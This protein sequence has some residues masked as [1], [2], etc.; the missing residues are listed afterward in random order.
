M[1]F[2]ID[3]I[4]LYSAGKFILNFK[5][6]SCYDENYTLKNIPI[7]LPFNFHTSMNKNILC[8]F[9]IEVSCNVITDELFH[10]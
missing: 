6:I 4:E 5:I 3:V 2:D 7:N 10:V 8:L 1:S 9:D